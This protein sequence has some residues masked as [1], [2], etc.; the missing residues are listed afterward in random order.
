MGTEKERV[1]PVVVNYQITHHAY[2]DFIGLLKS[3]PVW[4]NGY[5]YYFYEKGLSEKDVGTGH[6]VQ[7]GWTASRQV[8]EYVKFEVEVM[9]LARDLRKVV[10]E[11]GEETYW[12]RLLIVIDAKMV[13]DWQAKYKPYGIQDLYRQFYERFLVSGELKGYENTLGLE[14]GEL[15]TVLKTFLQ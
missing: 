7:S 14:V 12:A 2:M 10:L 4:F 5:K 6:E 1:I 11:D 8:T 13:K 9:I 15:A 3:L